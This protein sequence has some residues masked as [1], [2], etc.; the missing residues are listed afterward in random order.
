M[1]RLG[2]S[3]GDR[4]SPDLD[5]AWATVAARDV[6]WTGV[7]FS[8]AKGSAAF[9][10]GA[11]SRSQHTSPSRGASRCNFAHRTHILAGQTPSP[12]GRWRHDRPVTYIPLRGQSRMRPR[13]S[14]SS[15]TR[16]AH[17]RLGAWW[18][19]SMGMLAYGTGGGER[20]LHR[21]DAENSDVGFGFVDEVGDAIPGWHDVFK[22]LDIQQGPRVLAGRPGFDPREQV[23][24]SAARSASISL[25]KS[26]SVLGLAKIRQVTETRAVRCRRGVPVCQ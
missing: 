25:A 24:V 18:H 14:L 9:T 3:F 10:P 2:V 26:G 5:L 11:I 8:G 22:H 15:I 4:M 16:L 12:R 6:V 20:M 21:S 19:R 17:R 13:T 7:L 1:A 23:F